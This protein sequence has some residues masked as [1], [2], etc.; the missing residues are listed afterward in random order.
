MINPS[1]IKTRNPYL[2][3]TVFLF[4][5]LLLAAND[6]YL[7]GTYGTW[8]TGKASD[9]AGVLILPLF[10]KYLTGWRNGVVVGLTVLFFTWFKSPL[11]EGFLGALNAL[12]VLHFSRVVDYTDLLAF[13]VLPLSWYVLRYPER[14]GFAKG[15]LFHRYVASYAVLPLCLL[16]FVATSVDEPFPLTQ[17]TNINCCAQNPV[18]ATVGNGYVYIPSAFTPD[19]DGRNDFFQIVADTNIIRIDS[20]RVY[21]L[22]DSIVVFS[23]DSITD[24]S[25]ARGFNGEVFGQTASV[26]YAFSISVTAADGTSQTL[27]N[28]VCALPC[29]VQFSTGPRFLSSCTFGS[30]VNA[31]GR[32]DNTIDSQEPLGC[33]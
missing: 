22:P 25:P 19:G 8:W 23:A 15:L 31:Q 29:P 33:Y 9:F 10:L 24:F 27:Q 12:E 26:S 7:K 2:V 14:F 28:L 32:F 3:N 21:S 17:G 5:L 18:E 11:S 13:S 16:L 20:F 1:T 4:G 30:Q 6:H